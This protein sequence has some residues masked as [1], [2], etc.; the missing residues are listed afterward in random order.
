MQIAIC[1]DETIF[2]E[3]LKKLLLEYSFSSNT[4]ISVQEFTEGETLLAA[5]SEGLLSKTDVLFLDIRMGKTNGLETARRLRD[6]GC[7]CLIIFL[8]GLTEYLQ[9]GYEVRAFRYLLKEQAQKELA[10]IM[11]ACRRELESEE[12]FVFSSDRSRY[13]IHKKD[14][15]YFESRKRIVCLFGVNENYQFYEKLDTLEKQLCRDGFLRCH[16]S[17]L[18]QERYVKGWRDNRLWLENGTELPVSRSYEK[19]VNQRLMLRQGI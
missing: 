13:S 4:D 15:L 10:G 2:R 17:F 14:I 9:K 3:Y 7:R 6:G 19:T 1:D 18:V 5:H 12:Y 8:T 16:R 11:D